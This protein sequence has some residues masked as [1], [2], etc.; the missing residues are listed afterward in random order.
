MRQPAASFSRGKQIGERGVERSRLFRLNV[1]A[2]AW[3]HQQ[4]GGGH[5][6]LEEHAAVDARLIL[7]ADDH[8]QRHR[9]ALEAVLHLPQGRTL[10]LEIEHG[11]RMAK[12]RMLGQLP[13]EFGVTARILVLERLPHRRVGIF[14]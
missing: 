5:G 6:A 12:R 13:R 14:H 9:E 1:V 8:Q 11:L 7:V 10:E 3:D 2:R 4:T